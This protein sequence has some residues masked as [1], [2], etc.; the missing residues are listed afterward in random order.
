MSKK[1]DP[2]FLGVINALDGREDV[3]RYYIRAAIENMGWS[4]TAL[5]EARGARLDNAL[6]GPWLKGEKIIA[7][8]LC[9]EP[10]AIWPVRY[11]KRAAKTSRAA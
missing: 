3:P 11:R 10:E 9:V 5:S 8:E 1:A 2:L 7:E 4:I 6:S